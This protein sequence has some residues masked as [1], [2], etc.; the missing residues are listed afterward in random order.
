MRLAALTAA[1][2]VAV[3]AASFAPLAHAQQC[4]ASVPVQGAPPPLPVFPADNWWNVDIS[5]APVDASSASFINFIGATRGM[6]PDFGGTA[7]GTDIYGFPY[8]IVDGSQPKQAV[9][10]DYADESDGVNA[11]GQ[12]IPFYPI[13]A[14]AITQAQWIEGGAPGSVDQ[15]SASDRHLLIIDCTNRDL[16]ELYNVWYSTSQQKWYAGSGAFFDLDTNGRRPQG[17]TSAD[18]SGMAVFPGLIRYDEAGNAAVPEINHALRVTVRATN[19]HV[20]PASHTAGG[21][22]GA[23]PLGARLRLKTNV[24]G[25]DPALRTND[26]IARKIFRAMQKYGLIVADNGSDLYVS[27]T[28]DVRWNNGVLNPAFSAIKASDF[29]V[30]QR[31]WTPPASSAALSAVS[32]SPNPV[33]GGQSST[34]TVTLTAAAPAGGANVA[35]SS[36]SGTFTVPASVVVAQGATSASFA[37]ATTAPSTSTS[38]TLSASYAGVTRTTVF[39][40]NPVPASLTA[41]SAAPNPVEGG[42]AAAGTVTLSGAAPAGGASIALSSNS[43]AFSVPASVTVA[44]GASSATFAI[45][46][47]APASA[48]TGTLSAVYAG[49]TR[50]ASLTVNPL[51]PPALSIADVSM[52]EGN[53]GTTAMTFTV[54][55]SRA[56]SAPVGFS[57]ATAD[58]PGRHRAW[59]SAQAGSDYVARSLGGQSIAAGQTTASFQV[60]VNGDTAAERSE[61]FAVNLSGV[62]GATLA[63]A[64]AIGTILNDDTGP[65]RFAA[66]VALPFAPGLGTS[67]GLCVGRSRAADASRL[68][69]CARSA[70]AQWTEAFGRMLRGTTP[71]R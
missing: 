2:L 9:T 30:I 25:S 50:T 54:R 4:P 68:A 28:F 60:T 32:A 69:A 59:Q 23:L 5:N 13:P 49:T 58:I 67:M 51:P 33:T 14:Q 47:T 57:V 3:L 71:V 36:A 43:S 24:N 6:H 61:L 17:W 34:G 15:R 18:A 40:V 12:G 10:F 27:G 19:G 29:E 66:H 7:G 48:T 65:A 38:A 42:Q 26:P 8:A 39:T 21:T 37:I 45:A 64:Q 62:S 55:L 53:A 70:S 35:L 56:A 44:Q 20:Y 16:Y 22:S 11:S 1:W 41:V 63:D 52:A 31:G 46:T